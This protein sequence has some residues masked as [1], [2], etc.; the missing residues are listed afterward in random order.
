MGELRRDECAAL[1]SSVLSSRP[2]ANACHPIQGS[3]DAREE[4]LAELDH[5]LAET[6]QAAD[7]Q[8]GS[9]PKITRST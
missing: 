4:Q 7:A 1:T 3:L 8:V 5:E 2:S 9:A 6:R